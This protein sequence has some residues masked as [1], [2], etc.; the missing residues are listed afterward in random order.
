MTQDAAKSS[1]ESVSA[2]DEG[3]RDS[4]TSLPPDDHLIGETVAQR[5]TIR[6]PLGVGR[7]S[8]T[9]RAEQAPLGRIVALKIIRGEESDDYRRSF[10]KAGSRWARLSHPNSVTTIDYGHIRDDLYFIAMEELKGQGLD[11]MVEEGGALSTEQAASITSQI[12][13]SLR[14]LH[15]LGVQHAALRP[16]CVRAFDKEGETFVKVLGLSLPGAPAL[17]GTYSSTWHFTAPEVLRGDKVEAASDIYSLGAIFF[18]LLTGEPPHSG[19]NSNAILDAPR[20][21]REF[22]PEI[23]PRAQDVV[24]LAIAKSPSDRFDGIED[25]L[26]ALAELTPGERRL[27]VEPLG[28]SLEISGEMARPTVPPEPPPTEVENVETPT[29]PV[30]EQEKAPEQPTKKAKRGTSWFVIFAVLALA[31][32]VGAWLAYS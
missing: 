15:Q 25:F 21:L 23:D 18:Y 30:E 3:S 20:R 17:S 10:L 12:G 32:C 8:R 22:I 11:A 7:F 14:E 6:A 29:A 27:S 16:S 31:A 26:A 28:G 1:P 2:T 13:R 9:Y 19:K 5:F 4:R 24:D